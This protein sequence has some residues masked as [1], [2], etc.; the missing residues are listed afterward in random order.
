V[1]NRQAAGRL[2]VIL[3]G[4]PLNSD[5]PISF[6]GLPVIQELYFLTTLLATR[7]DGS[8]KRFPHDRQ[9]ALRSVATRAALAQLFLGYSWQ[10]RVFRISLLQNRNA[11]VGVF[12]EGQE[13]L[14]GGFRLGLIA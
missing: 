10:L 11:G 8:A 12:P 6:S 3:P 2:P 9:P 1:L 14:V 4:T 7:L 5:N 13:I